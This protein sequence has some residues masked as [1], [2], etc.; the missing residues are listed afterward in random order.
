MKMTCCLPAVLAAA[1][2]LGACGKVRYPNTYV[3]NF[4]QPAPQAAPVQE[5]LGTVLVNELRCPDYLCRDRIVYRPSPEEVGFYEFHRW[6]MDPRMSLTQLIA[7]TLRA[8]SKFSRVTIDESG[9][10]IAY[11][12]NG[13]IDRLEEIDQGRD[14]TVVCTIS[15]ELVDARTGSLIWRDTATETLPVEERNVPGV[16]RTLTKAAQLTVDRLVDSL[17]SV[18]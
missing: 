6:A 14:V 17:M 7:D 1:L 10:E 15:A 5:T 13:R 9:S 3:L 11:M 2:L 4:P 18:V 8:R 16:V 12:L